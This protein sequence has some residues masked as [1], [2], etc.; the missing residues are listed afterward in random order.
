MKI[1]NF[2]NIG[3]VKTKIS[4]ELKKNLINDFNLNLPKKTTG[5][6]GSN[7]PNHYYITDSEQLQK[8]Q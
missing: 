8:K 1:F 2:P 3:M 6:E 5:L 7:I 4:D